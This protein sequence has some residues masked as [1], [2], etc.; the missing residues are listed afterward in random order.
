MR[1]T[2]LQNIAHRLRRLGGDR[3]P[4]IVESIPHGVGR[5]LDVGC[6]YGWALGAL[7]EKSDDLVGVD[8][9]RDALQQARAAFPHIEFVYQD[10]SA[11]PFEDDAF[12]AVILS[13]VIEHVG[14]ENKRFVIDEIYRVLRPGGLFVL[15]APYAGLLAWMDPMDFKRRFPGLYRRYMRI[16]GYQPS[17]A[18]DIGHKHVSLP[19]IESLFDDRFALERVEYCGLL[20]PLFSWVLAVDQRLGAL[21][22]RWHEAI[23]R[24]RAW[25]S[26]VSYGSILSYNIRLVARKLGIPERLPTLPVEA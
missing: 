13:E 15:T 21:P 7:T 11:L 8:M 25:E 6:S 16:S 20:T 9:D 2:I 18:V 22:T 24:L 17:T 4:F 14:D 3:T 10:A 12:D 1:K 5:V 26:G 19:E 23:G